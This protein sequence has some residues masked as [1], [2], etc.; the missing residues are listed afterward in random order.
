MA[1][2]V[3]SASLDPANS[4]KSEV[5]VT[6]PANSVETGSSRRDAHLRSAAF[7]ETETYPTI[8]FRGIELRPTKEPEVWTVVGNLTIRGATK[9]VELTMTYLGVWDDP[10]LGTCAR[11]EGTAKVNRKD[12]GV[13]WIKAIGACGVVIGDRVKLELELQAIKKR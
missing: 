5:S 11:F 3:G 6:I 4:Q 13:D 8:E 2:S 10:R 12:W 7:F 1:V 9:P